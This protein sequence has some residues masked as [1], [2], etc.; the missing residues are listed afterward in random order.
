MFVQ[1]S[2][3]WLGLTEIV[4]QLR[5]M[6]NRAFT[7]LKAHVTMMSGK[8]EKFFFLRGNKAAALPLETAP[9]LRS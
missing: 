5:H 1:K 9:R 4:N 2:V 3:N 8:K 7:H 6:Q